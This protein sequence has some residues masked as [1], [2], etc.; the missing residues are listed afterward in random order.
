MWIRGT[1]RWCTVGFN[2]STILWGPGTANKATVAQTRALAETVYQTVVPNQVWTLEPFDRVKVTRLDV[3]LDLPNVANP[4]ALYNWYVR[5]PHHHGSKYKMYFKGGRCTGVDH[6]RRDHGGSR[7]YPKQRA[8]T[9]GGTVLRFEAQARKDACELFVPNISYLDE[10]AMGKVFRHYFS[11]VARGLPR[12][13]GCDLSLIVNDPRYRRTICHVVGEQVLT[14]AGL[15]SPDSRSSERRRELRKL[16][17]LDA[18][19]QLIDEHWI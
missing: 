12:A 5:N 7:I 6:S 16:G 3:A 11:Q 17:A 13:D 1:S 9:K 14:R 4:E 8:S 15:L 2:P 10:T 19:E 18:V